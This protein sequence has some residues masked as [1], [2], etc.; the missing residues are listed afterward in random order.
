MT[1]NTR[2]KFLVLSLLTLIVGA[3]LFAFPPSPPINGELIDYKRPFIQ[4]GF[5]LFAVFAVLFVRLPD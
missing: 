4:A 1:V 3:L 2:Q 5:F